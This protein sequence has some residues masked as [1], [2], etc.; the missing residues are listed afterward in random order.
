[1]S[2]AGGVGCSTWVR[3]SIIGFTTFPV[4]RDAGRRLRA[5]ATGSRA[6]GSR[7]IDRAPVYR[8]SV[9]VSEHWV[10]TFL[11]RQ[12]HAVAAFGSGPSRWMQV[13]AQRR[14]SGVFIAVRS[15]LGVLLRIF[16][17]KV[18]ESRS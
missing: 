18:S 15:P 5:V 6:L 7:P 12:R 8:W 17:R 11:T 4:V 1:F 3:F 14:I 10:P 16:G 2:A 9:G 13:E